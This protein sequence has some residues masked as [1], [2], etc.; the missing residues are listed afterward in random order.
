MGVPDL[1]N[2]LQVEVGGISALKAETRC[3]APPR[4]M[5]KD[6]Q[7][8]FLALVLFLVTAAA[9]V[10]AFLNYRTES[11]FEVPSDGIWWVEHNGHLRAPRVDPDGPG[12]RGGLRVGDDRVATPSRERLGG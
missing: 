5:T 4:S 12:A 2:R 8:R 9:G 1:A 6:F 10:F 7:V 11:R 3:L